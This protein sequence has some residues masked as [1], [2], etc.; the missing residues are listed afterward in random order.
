MNSNTDETRDDFAS[1][2]S[3]SQDGQLTGEN[4]NFILK[5]DPQT[6]LRLDEGNSDDCYDISSSESAPEP[7]APS[8]PDIAEPAPGSDDVYALA[9]PEPR[10]TPDQ[11]IAPKE[12]GGGQAPNANRAKSKKRAK[13][14]DEDDVSVESLYERRR[15][16]FAEEEEQKLIV[17]RDPLPPLPFWTNIFKPFRSAGFL[18][19]AGMIAGTVFVPILVVAYIL[20]RVLSSDVAGC[21]A[22]NPDASVWMAFLESLWDVRFFFVPFCFVWGIFAVPLSVQ[23]FVDTASGADEINDWPEFS[24][25]GAIGQFLWIACLLVLAGI[26]GAFFFPALGADPFLGMVVSATIFAPIFYLSCMQADELFALITKDVALSLKRTFK[27]WCVFLGIGSLFLVGTLTISALLIHGAVSPEGGAK[28]SFVN[29]AIVS[30]ILAVF[31]SVVPSLYLRFLGRL[32]WIIEDD[33]RARIKEQAEKEA[34]ENQEEES[35]NEN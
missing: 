23:I 21:V 27:S 28:V 29:V 5:N 34:R 16:A 10:P 11:G 12:R 26:P 35:E 31:F 7:S 33:V 22:E 13:K 1:D 4:A 18:A 6:G 24:V 19:R 14:N 25:V 20:T 2:E 9:E 30:A 32:A 3:Q 8:K 17:E 15:R